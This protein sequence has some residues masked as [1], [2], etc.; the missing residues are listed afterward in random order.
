MLRFAFVVSLTLVFGGCSGVAEP[1]YS[2]ELVPCEGVVMIGDTP[3]ADVE[4]VFT[5][6]S[7]AGDASKAIAADKTD[8]D[9]RAGFATTGRT[10]GFR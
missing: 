6:A 4:V 5:P 8:K 7:L 3:A 1:T 9:V 2:A 10:V